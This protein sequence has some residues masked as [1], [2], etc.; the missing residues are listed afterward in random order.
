MSTQQH[1]GLSDGGS[2]IFNSSNAVS[3]AV[4]VCLNCSIAVDRPSGIW[5]LVSELVPNVLRQH[6]WLHLQWQRPLKIR[7]LRLE[8]P[9]SIIQWC[10]TNTRNCTAVKAYKFTFC[11]GTAFTNLTSQPLS[12]TLIT[13]RTKRMYVSK[14]YCFYVSLQWGI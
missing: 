11:C 10:G 13:Q 6:K 9:A 14:Y 7:L 12:L 8:C 1:H 2:I 5:H 3:S 4:Y